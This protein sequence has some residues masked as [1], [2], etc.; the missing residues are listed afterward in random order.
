MHHAREPASMSQLIFYMWYLLENY[1]TDPEVTYLVDNRE[2][3]FVPCINP[4]GCVYNQNNHPDGG[5]MWQEPPGQRRWDHGCG[6]EPQLRLALG[7][8]DLGSSPDGNSETFTA[9][10]PLFR[11]GNAG[12]PR[13]L[14]CAHGF[15]AAL[16]YHCFG[17]M[18]RSIPWA[19]EPDLLT[20]DSLLVRGARGPNSP[21][22][23]ALLGNVHAGAQLPD[24]RHPP[25]DWMYGEQTAKTEDP[26]RDS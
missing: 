19:T 8:D 20:P 25:D 1:G 24:E 14:Q 5:G 12:H 15:R 22:T 7:L 10:P 21:A 23:T 4:D 3:Y 18:V 2:M 26:G 11:T 16:N 13:L 17:D 9:A 6:P